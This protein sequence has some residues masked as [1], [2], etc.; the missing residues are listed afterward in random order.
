MKEVRESVNVRQIPFFGL[1]MRQNLSLCKILKTVYH[2][3][4]GT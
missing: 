3:G 2:S 4:E 1:A